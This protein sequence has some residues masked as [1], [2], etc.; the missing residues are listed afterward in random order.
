MSVWPSFEIAESDAEEPSI[1]GKV[2]FNVAHRTKAG[3]L[4]QISSCR[5]REVCIPGGTKGL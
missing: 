5:L 1:S 4:H 2:D 3:T